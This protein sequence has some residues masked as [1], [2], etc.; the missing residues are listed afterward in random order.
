[1]HLFWSFWRGIFSTGVSR[2]AAG[3]LGVNPLHQ[4]GGKL[5]D[6]VH[7]REYFYVACIMW[8][9]YRKVG[10]LVAK[11]G[12]FGSETPIF[13]GFGSETF[14]PDTLFFLEMAGENGS[15]WGEHQ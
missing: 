4:K 2:S 11:G 12:G 13:G 1:M 10:G 5:R 14:R 3:P 9:T 7:P 6:C 8:I 15:F